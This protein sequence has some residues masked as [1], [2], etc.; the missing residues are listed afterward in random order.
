MR[1]G[2]KKMAV[3]T[4]TVTVAGGTVTISPSVDQVEFVSGDF[5]VF[6][7][8]VGTDGDILV[9]VTGGPKVVVAAAEFGR[10]IKLQPPTVDGAGN[11]TLAFTDA[12]GNAGEG[13]PGFP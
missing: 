12:G 9:Q 13:S 11:V 5:L 2:E 4:Y 6:S 1:K 3:V 8:P 7:P 10:K